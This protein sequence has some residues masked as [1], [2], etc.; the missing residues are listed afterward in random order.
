MHLPVEEGRRR[1]AATSATSSANGHGHMKVQ[2]DL[3]PAVQ[4]D[5]A[6]DASQHRLPA[7]QQHDQL[8]QIRGLGALLRARQRARRRNRRRPADRCCAPALPAPRTKNESSP[9]EQLRSTRRRRASCARC[10]CRRRSPTVRRALLRERARLL[11]QLEQLGEQLRARRRLRGSS[12]SAAGWLQIAVQAEEA[13]ADH[14]AHQH[15][16]ERVHVPAE[17]EAAQCSVATTSSAVPR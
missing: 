16:G 12:R 4:P 6:A 7:A 14:D 5:V 13:A 11:V 1:C 2:P 9:T 3:Q 8:L 10:C 15:V 17:L